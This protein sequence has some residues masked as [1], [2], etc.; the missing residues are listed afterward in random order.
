[1]EFIYSFSVEQAAQEVV[2]LIPVFQLGLALIFV[3]RLPAF[4]SHFQYN[5]TISVCLCVFS[6]VPNWMKD[7]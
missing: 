5:L 4:F 6:T 2:S 1:M 7:I 3:I